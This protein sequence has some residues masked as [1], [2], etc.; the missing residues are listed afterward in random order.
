MYR[1]YSEEALI[2]YERLPESQHGLVLSLC[3]LHLK[4]HCSAPCLATP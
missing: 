1:I 4:L 2:L 3:L